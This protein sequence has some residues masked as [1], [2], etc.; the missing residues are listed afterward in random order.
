MSVYLFACL[1]VCLYAFFVRNLNVKFS[2]CAQGNMLEA[3]NMPLNV[4]DTH[5][6]DRNFI[7]YADVLSFVL[8]TS[9]NHKSWTHNYNGAAVFVFQTL[10]IL[11]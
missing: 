8:F 6:I 4:F 1:F 3:V 5:N 9:I 2:F 11:F 10:I 7:R